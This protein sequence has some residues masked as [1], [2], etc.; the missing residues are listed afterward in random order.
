M[1][2]YEMLSRKRSIIINLSLILVLSLSTYAGD[3]K[4]K[5]ETATGTPVLWRDP[6]DIASRNLFLGP[7]G[8]AMKPDLTHITFIKEETS[9][10]SKKYRVRDG[11]GRVWVAK[12]GKE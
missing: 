6:G 8:E 7:G 3:D 4:K 10:Y 11:Q 5:K 2:G 12:L 1:G 9:G